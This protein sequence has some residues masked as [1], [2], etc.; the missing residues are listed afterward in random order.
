MKTAHWMTWEGGVDLVAMT[1]PG[2]A[3][4]NV[5]LHVARIVHTPIGSA[6]AGIVFWQP[7]AKAPPA[8]C[9]FVCGDPR[10]GAWFGPHIFAG[11]P[12]EKV[13]ALAARITVQIDGKVASSRIEVGGKVFA[14][15][16]GE[17][18]AATLVHRAA[19]SPM[20]FAQQ[21]LEAAAGKATL[22]VDGQKVAITVPPVAMGGG[23]GACLAATGIYARP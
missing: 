16:L 19:G 12:F 11:T 10:I 7:D 23:P 18:G 14:V 22:E 6:P 5:I 4:P 8:L 2:L 21:G 15:T 1:Q 20:P 3:Q 9:G 17:L 13:P